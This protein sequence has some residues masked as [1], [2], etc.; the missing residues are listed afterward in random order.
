MTRR[1][2]AVFVGL[3]V[4]VLGGAAS[5]V[6]FSPEQ[7]LALDPCPVLSFAGGVAVHESDVDRLRAAIRPPPPPAEALRLMRAIAVASAIEHGGNPQ[8]RSPHEMLRA[9]GEFRRRVVAGNS[10]SIRQ[11]REVQDALSLHAHALGVTVPVCRE[12]GEEEER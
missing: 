5:I 4:L 3:I 11:N 1:R 8:I 12:R 9:Y 7:G 2:K 6:G 10:D